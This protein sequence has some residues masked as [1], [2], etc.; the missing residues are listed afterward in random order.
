MKKENEV[1]LLDHGSGGHRSDHL[2]KSHI[3]AAIGNP[4]LDKLGDGAVFDVNNS[5]LAFTTDSFVVDPIFFPGGS[6]GDLSVNG[7]VNDLSMCGAT[8]LFLS[9]AL[10]IEEGF[11]IKDLDRIMNDMARA[12]EN[13]D[14]KIITGD[15]KVVPKGAADKIFITT[16][17]IGIIE[18]TPFDIGSI[19][20]GDRIIVSGSIAD[21]GTAILASRENLDIPAAITSD[22]APLNHLVKIMLETGSKVRLLRDPT[23]GG[24]ATILN[25]IAQNSGLSIRINESSILV[26]KEV[27]AFCGILGIDP[28]YVANEGKL[29]AVVPEKDAEALVSIMRTHELGKDAS[30]IGEVL[31]QENSNVIMK[32]RIGGERIIPMLTGEPLPRIC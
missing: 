5:K 25:E 21:H 10:V 4:I 26:K 31:S 23:R 8:P 15:T 28:L 24:L 22:C 12:A 17:G 11:P 16:S 30:V 32:T 14:V 13:A 19:K 20:P 2:I 3:L 27:S 18:G 29:V 7:T 6:I 9:C 1:I